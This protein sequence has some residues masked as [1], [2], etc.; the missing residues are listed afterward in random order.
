[1]LAKFQKP[2]VYDRTL[3]GKNITKPNFKDKTIL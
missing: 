2:K 1:M 3:G